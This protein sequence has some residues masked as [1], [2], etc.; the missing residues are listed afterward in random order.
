MG[1]DG[2]RWHGCLLGGARAN[3]L[4]GARAYCE[5][6]F[7]GSR[8]MPIGLAAI[9]GARTDSL[10][11]AISAHLVWDYAVLVVFDVTALG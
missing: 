1:T 4:A 9:A 10:T 5:P 7:T 3:R 11:A 8:S 6:A 2:T